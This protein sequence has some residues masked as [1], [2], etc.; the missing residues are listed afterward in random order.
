MALAVF[1][2]KLCL[3]S[4]NVKKKR[5][6]RKPITFQNRNPV[7]KALST[8]KYTD[9]FLN[10][11]NLQQTTRVCVNTR[12]TVRKSNFAKHNCTKAKRA[13][14]ANLDSAKIKYCWN[15][16]KADVHGNDIVK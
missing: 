12:A 7:S 10:T 6:A 5:I 16:R 1:V 3:R 2:K 13:K 15:K 14:Y 8:R 11:T 4:A 9:T